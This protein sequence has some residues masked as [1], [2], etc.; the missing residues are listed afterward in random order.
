[1]SFNVWEKSFNSRV[2]TILSELL[3]IIQKLGIMSNKRIHRGVYMDLNQ[4]HEKMNKLF[5]ASKETGEL[6]QILSEVKEDLT[7][8]KQDLTSKEETILKYET[9]INELKERNAKLVERNGEMLLRIPVGTEQ[10]QSSPF[11]QVKNEVTIADFM[12]GIDI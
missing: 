4:F 10:R 6:G 7:A 1:M 11:E 9:E 5:E 8:V 2:N 3:I 12:E